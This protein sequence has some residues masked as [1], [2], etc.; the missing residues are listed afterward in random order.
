MQKDRKL[1]VTAMVIAALGAGLPAFAGSNDFFGS[2]VPESSP[3]N[4]PKQ[5]SNPY[6]DPTVPQGDFTAD[7]KRMQKKY[8]ASIT[9]CKGLIAKGTKMMESGQ[10]GKNDKEFKKGKILKEI[11]EKQLA[12]LAAN[13]PLADI[14]DDKGADKKKTAD[15]GSN[16]TQ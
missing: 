1:A 16:S 9:H 6:A 7:E 14:L 3:V 12:E 4:T 15:S 8:K 5:T 13:N 11:G 2:Q 10:R